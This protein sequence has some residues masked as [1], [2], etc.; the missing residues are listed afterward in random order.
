MSGNIS[1]P[2]TWAPPGETEQDLW[3]ERSNFVGV[4]LS[5]IAY[6]VHLTLFLFVLHHLLLHPSSRAPPHYNHYGHAHA[7]QYR[8]RPHFFSSFSKRSISW[9][10]VA[11][12]TWNFT[13]GT[14]GIVGESK[15]NQLTFVDDRNYPGGPNQF[16][17]DQ[18]G[19][20]AN[21][22]GTVA[23]VVL[24]WSADA[25]VVSMIILMCLFICSPFSTQYYEI[26]YP[27]IAFLWLC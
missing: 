17:I 4:V 19:D 5:S 22:F 6:G 1:D 10:L 12:I 25:L 23:Y 8:R 16:V 18:Y 14:F 24:Q 9:P 20:F 7:N 26:Y 15:F 2:S 13:L 11:Y 27:M 21:I 3:L